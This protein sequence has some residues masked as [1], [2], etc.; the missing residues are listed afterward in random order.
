M[1]LLLVCIVLFLETS[2]T[3]FAQGTDTN[4]ALITAPQRDSIFPIQTFGR[5]AFRAGKII[6]LGEVATMAF[7]YMMPE[8]FSNWNKNF[9]KNPSYHWKKAFTMPP[10]WDDDPII[11]NYVQHP[12][13]GAIYYNGMRSQ[14]ATKLQSF[15]FS[16]A[17]STFFEYFIESVAE[18]PSTQDLIITPLAGSIIGEIENKLTVKMKRNGFTFL[19]KVLVFFINPMY[20]VFHGYRDGAK[21]FLHY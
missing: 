13:A 6:L 11:V 2:L 4:F 12:L 19:E 21:D 7:F 10:K 8:S 20:V 14:G 1:R 15:L 16:L 17:E 9:Y 5:K 18:R 3:S